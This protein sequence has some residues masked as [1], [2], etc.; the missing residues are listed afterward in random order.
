MNQL[1]QKQELYV[2]DQSQ[3]GMVGGTRFLEQSFLVGELSTEKIHSVPTFV[4][5]KVI[6]LVAAESIF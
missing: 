5:T 2:I 4:K 6:S 1:C 3:V